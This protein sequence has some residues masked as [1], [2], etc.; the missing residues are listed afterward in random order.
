MD[1]ISVDNVDS[2]VHNLEQQ[3]KKDVEKILSKSYVKFG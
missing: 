3:G 2:F 1:E